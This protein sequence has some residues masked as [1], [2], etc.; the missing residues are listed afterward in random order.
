MMQN[1]TNLNQWWSVAE[2]KYAEVDMFLQEL[3]LRAAISTY[4]STGTKIDEVIK[5]FLVSLGTARATEMLIP[6][7]LPHVKRSGRTSIGAA[8]G[9]MGQL[10]STS[11]PTITQVGLLMLHARVSRD[12]LCNHQRLLRP[13]TPPLSLLVLRYVAIHADDSC[14]QFVS[15]SSFYSISSSSDDDDDV[16]FTAYICQREGPTLCHL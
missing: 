7:K 15:S 9:T 3:S 14:A 10:F 6:W 8:N 4:N 2:E 13:S 11:W 16:V 5:C 1:M 12:R